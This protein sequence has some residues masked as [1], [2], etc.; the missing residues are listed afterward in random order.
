MKEYLKSYQEED[1][2][3]LLTRYPN[4]TYVADHYNPIVGLPADGKVVGTYGVYGSGYNHLNGEIYDE[5]LVE[6]YEDDLP[7][8]NGLEQQKENTQ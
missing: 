3:C 2:Y 7:T 4:G 8:Q 1:T 5:C 6:F